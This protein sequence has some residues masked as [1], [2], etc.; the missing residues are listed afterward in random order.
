MPLKTQTT[1]E[2]DFN[3]AYLYY[4]KQHNCFRVSENHEDSI[5]LN[6]VTPDKVNDFISSYI[7]YVLEDT[8]LKE[9]FEDSVKGESVMYLSKEANDE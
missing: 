6:G 5:L 4:C 2:Y 3:N 7:E 9:V 1:V 8:D